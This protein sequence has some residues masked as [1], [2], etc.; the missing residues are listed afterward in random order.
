MTEF[1]IR[2][3]LRRIAGVLLLHVMNFLVLQW[4]G[5]RLVRRVEIDVDFARLA[6]GEYGPGQVG[7]VTRVIGL[8]TLRWVWPLTGWFGPL[9]YIVERP[10]R[11]RVSSGM[12]LVLRTDETTLDQA[13]RDE[14]IGN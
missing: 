5:I 1:T 10:R 2:Y 12:T 3:I 4:F 7:T 14:G 8:S 6:A 9:R 13:M 11:V